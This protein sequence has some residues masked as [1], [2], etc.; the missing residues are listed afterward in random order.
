MEVDTIFTENIAEGEE[1][2][3]EEEGPQ[4]RALGHTRSDGGGL[5]GEGFELN[6]LST[7]SEVGVKPVKGGVSD[8]NGGKSTEEDGMGNRV[9]GRTEI[10]EDE[11]GEQTRIRCHKK[12]ICDLNQG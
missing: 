4:D 7:A 2:D 3:D 11:Y 9:K 8:A 12:V 10:K 5:R 1:I 6:E